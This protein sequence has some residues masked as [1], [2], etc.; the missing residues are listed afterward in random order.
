MRRRWTKEL[1]VQNI[2]SRHE[3]GLLLTSSAVFR[4]DCRLGG[5]ALRFFGTWRAAIAAAGIGS[6]D[7]QQ[8]TNSRI[9]EGKAT[10]CRAKT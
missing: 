5:A 10:A 2:R 8:Q 4:E 6:N 9:L 1:V 7:H 3:K